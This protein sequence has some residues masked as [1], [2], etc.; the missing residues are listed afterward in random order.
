MNGLTPLQ[1]EHWLWCILQLNEW[2]YALYDQ[3]YIECFNERHR[4]FLS[5]KMK[6]LLGPLGLN[7]ISWWL[8]VN[9]DAYHLINKGL[10]ESWCLVYPRLY[11]Y[12]VVITQIMLLI[13]ETTCLLCL[14]TW[15]NLMSCN[16]SSLINS[17]VR[18]DI[19][20]IGGHSGV[21]PLN[22]HVPNEYIGLT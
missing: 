5:E 19:W 18:G 14:A 13:P 10:I 20:L 7:L 17:K 12:I 22:H 2:N 1:D 8:H 15:R 3:I 21:S 4:I 16:S 11:Q 9:T 6:R